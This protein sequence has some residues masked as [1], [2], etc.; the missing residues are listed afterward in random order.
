VNI[1]RLR[2]PSLG[3]IVAL[4]SAMVFG[5]LLTA[6]TLAQT[7]QPSMLAARDSL[8]KALDFLNDATPDKGGHRDRAISL[9]QAAI[10]Q[11]NLG[12]RYARMHASSPRN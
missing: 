4:L 11:V 9:T 1:P 7:Q 6:T 12:M 5:S 8:N 10:V 3:L 2:A